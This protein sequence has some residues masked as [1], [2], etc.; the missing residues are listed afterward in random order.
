MTDSVPPPE[1]EEEDLFSDEQ[2]GENPEQDRLVHESVNQATQYHAVFDSA[3]NWAR[4]TAANLLVE[5]A[6]EEDDETREELRRIAAVVRTVSDRIEQG[7]N[8]RSRQPLGGRP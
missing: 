3:K 7:D 4:D 1:S 2:P 5:A 6:L 8:H